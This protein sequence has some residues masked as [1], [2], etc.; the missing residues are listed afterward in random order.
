[1]EYVVYLIIIKIIPTKCPVSNSA[2]THIVRVYLHGLGQFYC[3]LLLWK[4]GN[5]V[6]ISSYAFSYRLLKFNIELLFSKPIT[7]NYCNTKLN[8]SGSMITSQLCL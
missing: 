8:E 4:F 1:M 6:W 7:N 5:T 3:L 2:A